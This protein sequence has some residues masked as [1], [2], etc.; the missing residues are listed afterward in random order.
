MS[1]SDDF[2]PY[3]PPK[4]EQ[5]KPVATEMIGLAR[6]FTIG[7]V[8][9]RSWQIL[10][11]RTGLVIGTCLASLLLSS[12]PGIISSI[13]APNDPKV[14]LNPLSLLITLPGAVF[15]IYLQCGLCTFLINLASGRKAEFNDL[16]RGGP[17]VIKAILSALLFGIAGGALFA[18]GFATVALLFTVAGGAGVAIGV[19]GWICVASVIIT[20][21]SQYFYL[22]VD[23]EIGVMESFNLSSQLMK[24]RFWQYNILLFAGGLINL[25]TIFSL[26]IGLIL[27]IPL[28][29]IAS[30]VFYLA[31]TGQPVAD[32]MAFHANSQD[33]FV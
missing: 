26:G 15:S 1:F 19:L 11:S 17:I 23:R 28:S 29:M 33:E 4:A 31:I 32:P 10:R 7:D 24:G 25:L 16:F 18:I 9:S 6:D 5:N 27:T 21:F 14:R 13:V 20:R 30:A 12:L 8:L 2:D 3:S 22:L